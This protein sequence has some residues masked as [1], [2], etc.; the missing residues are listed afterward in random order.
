LARALIV[1]CGCRGRALG[2]SLAERGWSLRGTTREAAGAAA[3]RERGIEPAVADPARPGS[4]LDLVGD[5]SVIHWLLGS[6][7]GEPGSI[8]PIHGERLETL[9]ARLVETPVRGFVYEANGSV[10]SRVLQRGAELVG[11]A[12]RRWRI[13]TEVV[14]AEP[15]Q[16]GVWTE[17]MVAATERVVGR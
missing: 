6:A 11:A 12:S 10:P 5:V 15:E 7:K 8:E 3:M 4:V 1:A 14:R 13:P 16:V 2:A 9:L 17:A